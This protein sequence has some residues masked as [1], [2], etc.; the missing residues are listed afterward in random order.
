M[1][2]SEEVGMKKAAKQIN[3]LVERVP[4][5]PSALLFECGTRVLCCAQL[6]TTVHDTCLFLALASEH[7]RRQHLPRQVSAGVTKN[8]G[9]C[10]QVSGNLVEARGNTHTQVRQVSA[11]VA[12]SFGRCRQVSLALL[13]GVGSCHKKL[14]RVLAPSML[15][16]LDAKG[17]LLFDIAAT[18]KYIATY[19]PHKLGISSWFVLCGAIT[20]GRAIYVEEKYFSD[21]QICWIDGQHGTPCS[22]GCVLQ[23]QGTM[24]AEIWCAL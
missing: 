7:T 5:E 4:F 19:T 15:H 16:K 23:E 21:D 6:A 14:R 20:A 22:T 17:S 2:E 24:K 13:A 1:T 12:K 3:R 8:F 10:R 18:R 11:G 9:R